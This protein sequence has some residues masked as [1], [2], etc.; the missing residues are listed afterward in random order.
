MGFCSSCW[1]ESPDVWQWPAYGVVAHAVEQRSR[2]ICLRMALGA[3]RTAVLRMMLV[4]SA[5]L[6]IIGTALGLAGALGATRFL[7]TMLFE[8]RSLDTSVYLAVV[9][10]GGVI[11]LLAS[12]VPARRAAVL[13]PIELLEG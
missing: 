12:Y 8:V 7:E 4:R 10:G 6:A 2:E 9:V 1:R 11:T 13:N 5:M 3:T